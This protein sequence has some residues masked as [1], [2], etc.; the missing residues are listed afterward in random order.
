MNLRNSDCFFN[1]S[2]RFVRK[3]RAGYTPDKKCSHCPKHSSRISECVRSFPPK[4]LL[5]LLDFAN[6]LLK[7]CGYQNGVYFYRP[8]PR[9][10]AAIVVRTPKGFLFPGVERIVPSRDMSGNFEISRPRS[11]VTESML[12]AIATSLCWLWRKFLTE[13]YVLRQSR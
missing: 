10:Q 5:L 9:M 6:H 12:S 7:S 1:H 11:L 3:Q 4:K 2:I 13:G 8:S